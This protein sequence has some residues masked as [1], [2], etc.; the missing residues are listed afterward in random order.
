MGAD[1]RV[2]AVSHANPLTSRRLRVISHS[3]RAEQPHGSP[4]VGTLQGSG[5]G[6]LREL[7]ATSRA[8]AAPSFGRFE[9]DLVSDG[10]V[11]AAP[12]LS[13]GARRSLDTSPS[14]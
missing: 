3:S 12:L 8:R 10:V 4:V 7:T 11:M 13:V 9:N 14:S 2:T 1:D 6:M 5:D